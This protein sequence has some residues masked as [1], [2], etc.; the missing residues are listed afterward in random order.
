MLYNFQLAFTCICSYNSYI[1]VKT[2]LVMSPYPQN[3]QWHLQSPRLCLLQHTMMTVKIS[4]I[5]L[6]D[7][8][9]ALYQHFT[10]NITDSSRTSVSCPNVRIN[11]LFFSVAVCSW[12][13]KQR[14]INFIA[15]LCFTITVRKIDAI[16]FSTQE[17]IQILQDIQPL[18]ELPEF[19]V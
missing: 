11:L 17:N 8:L 3:S 7:C 9:K 16:N 19:K 10:Y 14:M 4:F 12:L 2:E 5:F 1:T 18:K 15:R 6:L 13:E